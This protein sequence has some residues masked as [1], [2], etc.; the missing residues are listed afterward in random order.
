VFATGELH[1]LRL[2]VDES[3]GQEKH[4]TAVTIEQRRKPIA[5]QISDLKGYE[6]HQAALLLEHKMQDFPCANTASE[7][8]LPIRLQTDTTGCVS[9]VAIESKPIDRLVR[10][11]QRKMREWDFGYP[12]EDEDQGRSR[13]ALSFVIIFPR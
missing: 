11:T 10:C 1:E 12:G 13:G 9:S 6:R 4:L 3:A 2:R 8:S 5:T 7:V